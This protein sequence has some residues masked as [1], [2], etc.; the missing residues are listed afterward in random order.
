MDWCTLR[1]R[2]SDLPR[3]TPESPTCI[4]CLP[5]CE[6]IDLT[7]L[8]HICL[9]GDSTV[10]AWLYQLGHALD[11]WLFLLNENLHSKY[12]LKVWSE[13]N[14]IYLEN[15][16]WI[17]GKNQCYL[18]IRTYMYFTFKDSKSIKP[19]SDIR[20]LLPLE[21]SQPP[22]AFS[23]F[24]SHFFFFFFVFIKVLNRFHL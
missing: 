13:H 18:E 4:F 10:R 24:F 23:W 7:D 20:V 17:I 14:M 22:A 9:Y 15:Y 6:V 3:I 11:E 12:M 21:P 2:L 16:H 19:Q 1:L 8:K 5:M